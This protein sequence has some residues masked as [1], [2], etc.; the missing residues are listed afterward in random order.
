MSDKIRK[1]RIDEEKKINVKESWDI[2]YWC[3]EL[4]LKADELKDIVKEVGPGLH[5][6]RL[7]IAKKHMIKWPV[8]Y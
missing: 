1:H 2:N 5:D 3:D 6:V 8:S 4:N 7:H